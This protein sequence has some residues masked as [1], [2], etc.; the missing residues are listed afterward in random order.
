LTTVRRAV[1]RIRFSAETCVA[2]GRPA[3]LPIV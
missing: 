3:L 2:M 1:W